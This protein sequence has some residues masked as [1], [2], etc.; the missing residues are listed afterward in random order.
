[1]QT[2]HALER[3]IAIDTDLLPGRVVDRI[4]GSTR[5]DIRLDAELH[6][7]F[8][9]ELSGLGFLLAQCRR[10]QDV[11]Q[12]HET[13]AVRAFLVGQ[14][15]HRFEVV[16][17]L[18]V[19]HGPADLDEY[20]VGL[21][22][23]GQAAQ[24]ELDLAGDVRNHLYVATEI[25]AVPFLVQ[26]GGEDLPARGEVGSAQVQVEHPLVRAQVHVTFHPVVQDEHLAVPEGVQRAR[27]DVQVALQLD[28]RDL[29]AL[30]L[31]QLGQAG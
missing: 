3:D 6:D 31:E 11:G 1:M 19:A 15:A 26:D 14:F 16:G 5:D 25:I 12:R 24:L 17:V 7:L 27:I 29:Q 21:G 20:N 18:Q 9:P 4:A 8:D 30:V 22:L 28:R 2:D 23:S 13:T 10:F